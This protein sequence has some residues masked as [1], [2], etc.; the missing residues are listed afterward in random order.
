MRLTLALLVAACSTSQSPAPGVTGNGAAD[1]SMPEMTGNIEILSP[2]PGQTLRPEITVEGLA[3][4]VE[5]TVNG[6]AVPVASGEFET[7]LTLPPGPQQIV[8]VGDDGMATVDVFVDD[9]NPAVLV[10][11]PELASFIEGDRIA[12]TGRVSDD[13]TVTL[14]VEGDPVDLDGE[15]RFTFE[16]A[17]SPGGHR[18]RLIA[19]D[20]AGNKGS[21][22]VTAVTG[23]FGPV[24]ELTADAVHVA[25]GREGLDLVAQV[26]AGYLTPAQIRPRLRGRKIVE[27]RLY[28]VTTRG[29]RH[30]SSSLR[31]VPMDGQLQV[32]V[33]LTD[34]VV[35]FEVDALVD[36]DGDARARSVRLRGTL[37]IDQ[38]EDRRP[39]V[40]LAQRT[41][42]MED[43]EVDIDGLPGF[44]D[45]G[46][47]TRE[48]KGTV[49]EAVEDAVEEEVPG[50]IE[51]AFG[52]INTDRSVTFMTQEVVFES[53]LSALGVFDSGVYAGVDFG[54]V[55]EDERSMMGPGPLVL[56]SEPPVMDGA[57]QFEVA[58]ALDVLNAAAYDVW[59]TGTLAL[60]FETFPTE[61]GLIDAG[62]L[63]RVLPEN[64][65][66]P[67]TPIGFEISAELPPVVTQTPDDHLELVVPDIRIALFEPGGE[68]PIRTITAAVIATLDARP[69]GD[70]IAL[71][72]LNPRINLDPADDLGPFS[73]S[74]DQVDSGL[75]R[76]LFPL[77]APLAE[78]QG[79]VVPN[80]GGLTA[81]LE[82]IVTEGGF[83]R[84]NGALETA[85]P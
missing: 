34:V 15:G 53:R 46:L 62:L 5:V 47:I 82:D 8:V 43:F 6:V 35:P 85:N 79:L 64:D 25:L 23:T 50:G 30:G 13:S 51:A 21:A 4:G 70:Q 83:V 22:V 39:R 31:L 61:G 14:T 56:A 36:L 77:L 74:P 3:T 57:A 18:L 81:S 45:K 26:A 78:G 19:E 32:V 60:D 69:D 10:E 68:E 28:D 67:S 59:S 48:V 40:R 17:V 29:Y 38:D 24:G 72:L 11:S 2:S 9:A 63:R 33:T 73:A 55:T 44:V 54:L 49:E 37:A 52:Y 27:R 41:V 7:E 66:D 80:I 1:A 16:R 58:V 75:L 84:C 20:A 42:S 12:V 76:L 65:L 71:D